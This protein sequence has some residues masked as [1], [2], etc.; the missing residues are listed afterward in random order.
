M[1]KYMFCTFMLV[2]S[3]NSYTIVNFKQEEGISNWRVVDDGV[4]GGRSVGNFKFDKKGFGVFEGKVSLENNGGFSSL[5]HR[6]I[7]ISTS[8]FKKVKL[9]VKGDGK[10]YQF[11]L[12]NSTADY[13]SYVTYFSTSGKWQEIVLPLEDFYPSFRGTKLDKANFSGDD[14][15]EIAFLISNKKAENFRLIIEK[16]ELI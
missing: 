6:F 8:R 11:R 12:K 2:V 3:I 16:V 4:M 7:K 9:T 15:E 13:Y 1:I 5:R 10:R 14:I